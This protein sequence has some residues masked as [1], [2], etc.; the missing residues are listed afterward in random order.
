M[1]FY[2]EA[3]SKKILEVL[4]KEFAEVDKVTCEISSVLARLQQVRQVGAQTE[5]AKL[6][7]VKSAVL[8]RRKAKRAKIEED[9]SYVVPL[10]SGQI[11]YSI[12]DSIGLPYGGV[13]AKPAS[14]QQQPAKPLGPADLTVPDLN[15][16][17]SNAPVNRAPPSL[18]LPSFGSAPSLDVPKPPSTPAPAPPSMN[19]PPPY[20]TLYYNCNISLDHPHQAWVHLRKF[21]QFALICNRPPP[22]PSMP[23]PAPKPPTMAPP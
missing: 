10:S 18:D 5:L 15:V 1:A 7:A 11:D 9:S 20:V 17:I 19:T 13:T 6:H 22:P 23:P 3:T 8:P 12:Y 16:P 2:V 4:D 21:K 14:V